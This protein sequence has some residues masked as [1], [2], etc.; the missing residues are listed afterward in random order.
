MKWR[1]P[2]P[3]GGTRTSSSPEKVPNS[4]SPRGTDLAAQSKALSSPPARGGNSSGHNSSRHRRRSARSR[5]STT[6]RPRHDWRHCGRGRGSLLSAP[7]ALPHVRARKRLPPQ[8]RRSSG[9]DTGGGDRSPLP[10]PRRPPPPAPPPVASL[11]LWSTAT[12][13]VAM[14]ME[15]SLETLG[16][17]RAEG[18][19]KQKR[20]FKKYI[21]VLYNI[22]WR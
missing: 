7:R 12:T 8:R 18:T 11:P 2:S 3:L 9:S 22:L 10:K 16:S 15:G 20:D 17:V 14:T 5:C 19:P 13:G 1:R 21:H 4:A 6:R